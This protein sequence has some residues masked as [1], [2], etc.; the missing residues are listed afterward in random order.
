MTARRWAIAAAL[1]LLLLVAAGGILLVRGSGDG[2]DESTLRPVRARATVSDRIVAFGDTIRARIDVALDLRHVD[3]AAVKVRAT[4]E[5]WRR[6]GPAQVT[7]TDAGSSAHLQ[8]TYVLRCMKQACAPERDTLPFDF[9]AARIEF[10]NRA[11]GRGLIR[12]EWPRVTLHSRIAAGDLATAAPWRLDVTNVPDP[13]YRASPG[14]LVLLLAGGSVLLL[15]GGGTLAYA[16][17]PRRHVE[18][19]PEP[20]PEPELLPTPLE[21]ALELLEDAAR[22]NGA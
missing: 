17:W 20:E 13:S 1:V 7:R 3:P 5:A 12:A 9:D 15:A 8:I 21:L 14:L 10:V 2:D 11:G 4:F 6:V 18:P 19:E 16:G 22:G